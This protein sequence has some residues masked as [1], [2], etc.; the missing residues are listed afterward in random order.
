MLCNGKA[1][2]FPLLKL[3]RE[4]RRRIAEYALYTVEGLDW[5]W[6]AAQ[7]LK[8]CGTFRDISVINALPSVCKQLYQETSDLV[9][10]I[11]ILNFDASCIYGYIPEIQHPPDLSTAL[12]AFEFFWSK[13]PANVRGGVQ[14]IRMCTTW[15]ASQA[16]DL[17]LCHWPT[18]VRNSLGHTSFAVTRSR[19]EEKNYR[20]LSELSQS[21]LHFM[22]AP[23]DWRLPGRGERPKSWR[24]QLD[25]F[26]AFAEGLKED[27]LLGW[28]GSPTRKWKITPY[29]RNCEADLEF[30]CS[31]VAF[32]QYTDRV[33]EWCSE[34]F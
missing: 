33:K 19:K 29:H 21:R 30:M 11:N 26:V 28:F 31:Y 12:Y 32:T 6:I 8:K 15:T 22:I 20:I 9:F 17:A 23:L 14:R 1:T 24:M 16:F 2:P 10:S 5:Q 4:I 25:R 7:P 13:C 34:G 3:P 27:E 18:D